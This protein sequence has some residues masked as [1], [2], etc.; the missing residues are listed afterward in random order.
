M[1]HLFFILSL[2][3][4]A[5]A[6]PVHASN[7]N[8]GSTLA[9]EGIIPAPAQNSVMLGDIPLM[10]GLQIYH[11]PELIHLFADDPTEPVIAVGIVDVDDV[12]NFYKHALPPLGWQAS[13]GRDYTQSGKTLHIDAHADGKKTVVTFTIT[14]TK[15]N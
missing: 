3:A 4:L 1:K 8:S 11:D 14:G 6:S 5:L 12:Y 9:D 2:M 10:D 7:L 13:S 15:E